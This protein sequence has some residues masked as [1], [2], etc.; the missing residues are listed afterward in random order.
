MYKKALGALLFLGL[1][2]SPLVAE[3]VYSLEKAVYELA[4][5]VSSK[6]PEGTK[7]VLYD[8][9]AETPETST[10]LID[11]CTRALLDI[12]SLRIVDR[13]S[14]DKIRDELSFQMSGDVSD[15]SAQRLGAMLGAESLLTGSFDSYRGKYRLT[16]K[17]IQVA[18]SEIQYMGVVFIA[19]NAETEAL[20][21]RKSGADV[22]VSAV[23]SAARSVMDFSTRF[24]CSSINPFFGIGSY[25]QGDFSGGSTVTFW[26]LA[27]IGGLVYSASQND[28]TESNVSIITAVSRT[29]LLTTI[30]YA[31]IR[32]WRYN[33]DPS[34]ASTVPSFNIGVGTGI[35]EE[36]CVPVSVAWTI[37]Y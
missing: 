15:E 16:L 21:G 25:M 20:L 19:A 8:I 36:K 22:A 11:E 14:L 37:R 17:S 28:I 7:I 6:L 27:S 29:V 12:G 31:I 5:G 1:S 26:E 3:K 24:V 18:T 13:G 30:V 4:R 32:P 35:I 33:R 34:V 9:S 23:G 10:F 2:F